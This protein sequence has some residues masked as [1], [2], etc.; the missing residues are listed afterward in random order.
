[1]LMAKT[2]RLRIGQLQQL[3]RVS[4]S[5][6]IQTRYG[7]RTYK[8]RGEARTAVFFD[9][10]GLRFEYEPEGYW[11]E[12]AGKYLPDFWIPKL[13]L[14]Y[15]VKSDVPEDKAILKCHGLADETGKRVAMSY[16]RPGLGTTVASFFPGWDGHELRPMPEFFMQWLRPAL[17]LAA[18]EQA[19]SARFEFGETPKILQLRPVATKVAEGVPF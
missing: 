8:A 16:G 6:A 1:M 7:G 19:Q 10:C 3:R 11:L 4:V 9:I 12:E 18:I 14:W 15:E 17:V 5:T 2:N 13:E